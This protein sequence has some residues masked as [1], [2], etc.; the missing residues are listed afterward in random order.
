LVSLL[1]FTLCPASGYLL[2]SGVR[3]TA[4]Q[5]SVGAPFAIVW[6]LILLGTSLLAGWLWHQIAVVVAARL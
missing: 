1:F 3:W 5:T 4:V 6:G 2:G